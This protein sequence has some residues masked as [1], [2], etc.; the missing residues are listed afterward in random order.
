MRCTIDASVFVASA[1]SDEP[2]YLLSRR[3]LRDAQSLEVYCPTLALT[4]CAA[5]I[6]RQT[7]DPSLAEEIVSII[8]DFPGIHLISLDLPTARR[9]AQI[10]IQHRLR[11]AD[12]TYVA[13]ADAFGA[14]L[15]SWD[16]EMLR[17]CP[18]AVA[19]MT[20]ESWCESQ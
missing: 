5:A 9:A 17:R 13:V 14:T 10:A 16:Q 1:R 6:A 8:E 2:N 19:T 18:A 7:G 20:P 12:A 3:F 11:G 15:I 4:E